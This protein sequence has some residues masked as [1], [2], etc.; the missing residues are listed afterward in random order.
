MFYK[1]GVK[2]LGSVATEILIQFQ[3][4]LSE[5]V[6][7]ITQLGQWFGLYSDRVVDHVL[8]LQHST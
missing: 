3:C 8:V 4:C 7:E 6:M 5:E 1:L 2:A